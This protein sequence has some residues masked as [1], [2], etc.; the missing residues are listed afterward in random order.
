MASRKRTPKKKKSGA[1]VVLSILAIGLFVSGA[2]LV[3]GYYQENERIEEMRSMVDSD[4]FYD[5]ITINGISMNGLTYEQGLAKVEEYDKNELSR[6]TGVIRVEGREWREDIP[7]T[8]NTLD[9]VNQAYQMGRQGEL[10][11]R[12]EQV[13]LMREEGVVL[14]TEYSSDPSA[15][16]TLATSIAAEVDEEP[17][18]A[19][20]SEFN[21]KKK[22]FTFTQE[23]PGRK[24]D[25]EA[26]TAAVE[27]AIS[28][29]SYPI[30]VTGQMVDVEPL[31]T[32]AELEA[33]YRLLASFTTKTTSNSA[34]NNNIRLI[35]EALNGAMV[36]PGEVFS[37]NDTTG[38][39]S[40]EKGY[41]EAGAILNGRLV[42]E[43][44]GGVCQV[45]TTMFNAIVRAGLEITERNN[46]SYPIDYVPRGHDA[47]IDYPS[48]DLK[49][50]N[51]GTG[52]VYIVIDFADRVLTVEVYGTPILDEGVE[53]SLRAE[54]TEEI[55]MPATIYEPDPAAMQGTEVEDRKGRTGYR[56]VT[57]IEYKKG[58]TV[59]ETKSF[60]SYYRPIAPVILYGTAVVQTPGGTTTTTTPTTPPA[61]S[62][63][64][65]LITG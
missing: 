3:H 2:V 54:T 8:A 26:L 62:S 30:E 56:M 57:Y 7:A 53:V 14:N 47:M 46:H 48:K 11:A 45:S 42:P 44:G 33:S 18:D 6:F 27:A 21:T 36:M 20:V 60:K 23:K 22:S 5:G 10:Q 32:Q 63:E 13:M 4:L 35:S 19:T 39:R 40:T 12:Y 1:A 55:P 17:V 34:R 52:P 43:P 15:L 25:V 24:L 49:F 41:Q 58:D 64:L 38:R 61:S 28:Q 29:G 37:I 31:V 50:T 65:P 59:V 16:L 51:N 9:I